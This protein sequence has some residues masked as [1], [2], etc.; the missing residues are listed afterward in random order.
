M[1]LIFF[2]FIFVLTCAVILGAAH[3]KSWDRDGRLTMDDSGLCDL[4]R[5]H[6]ISRWGAH[7]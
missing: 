4:E 5:F 3:I 2:S 6:V 7:H 1:T